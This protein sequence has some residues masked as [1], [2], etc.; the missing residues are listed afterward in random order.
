MSDD[1]FGRYDRQPRFRDEG[2]RRPY[3]GRFS[4]RRSSAAATI[5]SIA[6]SRP[7]AAGRERW[8]RRARS[9]SSPAWRR[10]A[11]ALHDPHYS[12]WRRRQIDALDRDYDEY[13]RENQSPVRE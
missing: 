6:A 2:Y 8:E 4:G 9:A 3:T 12:E 5:A 10:P 7:S 1:D 13:R 11:A